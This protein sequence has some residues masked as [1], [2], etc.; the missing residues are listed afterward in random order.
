MNEARKDDVLVRQGSGAVAK[1]PQH[2]AGTAK[3]VGDQT[4]RNHWPYGMELIL[5]GRRNAEVATSTAYG[6]EQIGLLVLA[7]PY[8][9]AFGSHQLDGAQ[10]VEGETIFAHQ[11]AHP[12][13]KSEP[14]YSCAGHDPTCD[15]QAVQLCFA[16]ELSP[17]DAT[18]GPH[19]TTLGVDVDPLHGREINHQPAID[20]GASRHIV[21][22][23]TVSHLEL[24][25]F[26]KLHSIHDVGHATASGDQRSA[27][28]HPAIVN[29]PRVLVAS[30]R[31]L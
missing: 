27:L 23:A 19:R 7:G 15:G 31:R 2:I 30:M 18:L 21:A 25:L 17:G 16:V 4:A 8:H 9:L 29:L 11:P 13:A 5:K 1:S 14:G 26:S 10:I 28:V 20:G 3:W 6:P 22:S 24:Q 12:P